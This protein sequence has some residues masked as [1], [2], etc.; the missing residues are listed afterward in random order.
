MDINR[1]KQHDDFS[2][3]L[4]KLLKVHTSKEGQPLRFMQMII[5]AIGINDSYE[6]SDSQL[7][8]SLEDMYEK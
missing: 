1:I 7:L 5:N 8:E 4:H 2:D 3:I 6:M